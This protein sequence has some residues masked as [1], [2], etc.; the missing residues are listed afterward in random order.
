MDDVLQSLSSSSFVVV[1]VVVDVYVVVV[2]V[3]I[4]VV[5]V[6]VYVV[7]VVIDVYIVVVVVVLLCLL[8]RS[9]A[10]V[11]CRRGGT[12]RCWRPCGHLVPGPGI[13]ST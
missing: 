3:Y 10:Q 9:Q 1:V 12:S 4:A 2:D 11:A 6:D 13:S 5:V 8:R 7:V